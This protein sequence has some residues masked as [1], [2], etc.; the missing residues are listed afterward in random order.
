MNHNRLRK[1]V[2]VLLFFVLCFLLGTGLLMQYR[3]V[4]GSRGGH[5]YT[6]FGLDRHQWGHYHLWAAYLMIAMVVVHI[7][8]NFAFVKNI[9][10][11]KRNWLLISFGLIGLIILLPFLIAP[12][13]RSGGE[14]HGGG[15]GG[16]QG[17]GRVQER[18]EGAAEE[19]GEGRIRG[20]GRGPGRGQGRG[21]GSGR[22]R[23]Q[24]GSNE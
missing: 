22:G 14:G 2:D 17:E 7:V 1:Y 24:S 3:L 12:A 6:L 19:H 11:L 15:H 18:R 9:V 20:E 21:Y 16:G 5:G 13:G 4:P 23:V 10:A 8:V